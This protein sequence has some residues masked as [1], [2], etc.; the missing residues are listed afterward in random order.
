MTVKELIE[1]LEHHPDDSLILVEGSWPGSFNAIT[2]VKIASDKIIDENN[3][4]IDSV[5]YLTIG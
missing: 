4:E 2:D 1:L 5:V 3:K